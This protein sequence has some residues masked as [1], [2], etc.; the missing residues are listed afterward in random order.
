MSAPDLSLEEAKRRTTIVSAW[1]HLG[2][3]N[4]PLG[5]TG[6]VKSPFRKDRKASF[7]IYAKGR[8]WADKAEGIGG[9]VVNFIEWTTGRDFKEAKDM[10]LQWS[11]LQN[12]AVYHSTHA[13][14]S[15]RPPKPQISGAVPLPE[16][17]PDRE[18]KVFGEGIAH[19]LNKP[20]LCTQIDQWRHWPQGTTDI[21]V[22][23]NLISG[24]LVR[25]NRTIAF[26]VQVPFFDHLGL[27]STLDVSFHARH[28]P[29]KGQRP[30]WS[31]HPT[32]R[33]AWPFVLG[34][35]HITNANHVHL[36]EGQWDAIALA[37][38][39]GW[40]AHDTSWPD[41]TVILGTRGA[42]S[43]SQ[44]LDHWLPKAPTSAGIT[45]YPDGDDAGDKA[46][47]K[48]ITELKQLGFTTI[49]ILAGIPRG[50]DLSDYL[51]GL[52]K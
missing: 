40:L 33:G 35:G 4:P 41:G 19:L 22:E 44:L 6:T 12:Q 50:Q 3:P 20:K 43:L 25:G 1:R 28:K 7:S 38:H 45:I 17:I 46:T 23:D 52:T 39:Q 13:R 14:V 24:P 37:A 10:L 49:T 30:S 21:L 34:G 11:G 5:E 32:G 16:H 9:D 51:A 36:C 8:R 29:Q 26:P 18:L 31:F 42:T 2:L 48:L 15:P 47:F 27:L